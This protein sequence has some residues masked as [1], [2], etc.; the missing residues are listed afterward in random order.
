MLG[1][2]AVTVIIYILT[3]PVG[4]KFTWYPNTLLVNWRRTLKEFR[5]LSV[6]SS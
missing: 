6:V 3:M 1:T 4:L 5:L 2:L